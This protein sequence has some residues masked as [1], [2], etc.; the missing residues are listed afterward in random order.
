MN[1]SLHDCTHY[2]PSHCS[3]INSICKGNYEYVKN[4]VLNQRNDWSYEFILDHV[5]AFDRIGCKFSKEDI[6]FMTQKITEQHKLKEE[7]LKCAKPAYDFIIKHPWFMSKYET[8]YDDKDFRTVYE[9]VETEIVV[10]DDD[11]DDVDV[12][13]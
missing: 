8:D 3:I 9:E 2:Q 10:D 4:N 6:L 5:S 11:V 1:N 12:D 7:F 13:N